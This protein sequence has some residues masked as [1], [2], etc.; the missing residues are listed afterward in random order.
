MPTITAQ[1]TDDFGLT[2]DEY[3][4]LIDRRHVAQALQTGNG[5]YQ[6]WLHAETVVAQ[7]AIEV[8]FCNTV[9]GLI[10]FTELQKIIQAAVDQAVAVKKG[11]CISVQYETDYA[12]NQPVL[13]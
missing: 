13:S 2:D 12:I 11:S 1:H 9:N 5:H 10:D 6:E 4:R 8:Q 3:A 7:Y